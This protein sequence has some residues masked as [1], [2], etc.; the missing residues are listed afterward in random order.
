M[1]TYIKNNTE[2]VLWSA[3]SF[4]LFSLLKRFLNTRIKKARQGRFM[5]LLSCAPSLS[6]SLLK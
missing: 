2:P 1:D 6:L 4:L 3:V 5:V